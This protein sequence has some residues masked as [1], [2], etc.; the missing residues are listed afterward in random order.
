MAKLPNAATT[1]P[2]EIVA[3]Q[4]DSDRRQFIEFQWQI[5]KDDPYWVPPIISERMAFYDKTKNPFFEH[6]DAQMFIAKRN[7]NIVGTIVAI[8]NN[9]H[10]ETW[11]EKTAFFG[12]FET[13][14]DFAVASA[15]IETAKAWAR[16]RGFNCLRGPTTL[17]IYDECGLLVDG[18]DDEPKAL[19]TYNPRYTST[20]SINWVLRR[21]WT[22]G[23]GGAIPR[24]AVRR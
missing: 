17:S 10:N 11:N 16:E 15:L 2:I 18:F 3:C 12:G 1:Q 24:S 8:Q 5:Y 4:T 14:N 19:M 23:R 22:C 13:I 7:G 20:S 21:R 9:R 6:S